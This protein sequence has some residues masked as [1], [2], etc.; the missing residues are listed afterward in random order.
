M[1]GIE[2]YENFPVA[3]WLCPPALRPPILA[4]YHFARTGDDLAD[5]GDV[6][7]SRRLQDLAAYRTELVACAQSAQSH[8][9]E[10]EAPAG[11]WPQVFGPLARAIDSHELP[12][13]LLHQ[14]LD[15]FE[16]DVRYTDEQHRY[17]DRGELLAYC[18]R[19]ANPIGRLLLHLYGVTDEVAL[20]QSDA[21][22]SALQLINFWQDRSQD[23]ARGRDYLPL[24]N[25]VRT[26]LAFANMLMHRGMPLAHQ[27]PGRLGW[28]L[29][30]VVQGGLRILEKLQ[31]LSDD[32]LAHPLTQRRPKLSKV[33][34]PLLLWRAVLMRMRPTPAAAGAQP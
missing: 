18:E 17:A 1:Q 21:V 14:L 30:L 12:V 13:H 19:S 3:S 22:C 33:E 11:R 28:E 8:H 29:R 9:L 15:A 34:V 31:Q 20:Q 23:M 32:A 2:H 5:E 24:G 16:Q 25:D 26:E 27:L 10:S 4:I 6:S 7:A